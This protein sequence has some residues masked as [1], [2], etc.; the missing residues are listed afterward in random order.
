M[1]GG[2]PTTRALRIRDR[3]EQVVL[4]VCAVERVRLSELPVLHIGTGSGVWIQEKMISVG[5]S[6]APGT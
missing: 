6:V 5:G 3:L 2:I 1:P 4:G